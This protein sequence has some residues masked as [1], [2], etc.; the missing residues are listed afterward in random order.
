MNDEL[1]EDIRTRV[2]LN[3]QILNQLKSLGLNSNWDM[4]FVVFSIHFI[5]LLKQLDSETI[6]QVTHVETFSVETLHELQSY[7]D[8]FKV[9]YAV[10]LKFIQNSQSGKENI[11]LELEDY[12]KDQLN[13]EN[14]KLF[15]LKSPLW[16]LAR[17][18]YQE[19]YLGTTLY[20]KV[21][22]LTPLSIPKSG[23]I[24]E[25]MILRPVEEIK[26]LLNDIK[27]A[28]FNIAIATG[29]PRTETIVPFESFGLKSF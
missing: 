17:A 28:G 4:L 16:N 7:N 3:D 14:A 11:Y 24:Y 29:R 5:H 20:E 22:K 8:Q 23:F 25:E 12:A 21:E 18:V 15:N 6:R 1:I 10:P 27:Q 26:T 13:I 9:N 19:W 2:F